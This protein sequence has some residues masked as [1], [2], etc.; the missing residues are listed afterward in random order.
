MGSANALI[1]VVDADAEWACANNEYNLAG[2][3]MALKTVGDAFTSFSR[4]FVSTD[5]REVRREYNDDELTTHLENCKVDL[6]DP[7][8]ELVKE[9]KLL[10]AMGT[11]RRGV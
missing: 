4:R 1:A 9:V 10:T 2:V 5:L 6:F 11:A 7:V 8:C 3:K